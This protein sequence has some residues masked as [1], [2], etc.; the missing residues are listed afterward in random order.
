MQDGLVERMLAQG[1][2]QFLADGGQLKT[3]KI[4]MAGLEIAQQ[5]G[6]GE[7]GGLLQV[8]IA[9]EGEVDHR[10]EGEGVHLVRLAHLIDRFVAKA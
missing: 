7:P 9:V 4:L 3:K 10:Q 6:H 8:H 5:G 2:P 1:I